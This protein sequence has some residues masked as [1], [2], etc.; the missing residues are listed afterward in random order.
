MLIM[1]V[2]MRDQH[3]HIAGV[4]ALGLLTP[5]PLAAC[6]LPVRRAAKALSLA[7]HE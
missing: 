1:A 4:L 3:Q 6:W 2:I 7:A 5:V